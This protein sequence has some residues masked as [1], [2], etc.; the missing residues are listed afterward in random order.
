[1]AR[2]PFLSAAFFAALLSLTLGSCKTVAGRWLAAV[3]A[4]GVNLVFQVLDPRIED[5]DLEFKTLEHSLD[6]CD[7][8]IGSLIVDGQDL[9]VFY[10][11][12]SP[13]GGTTAS[14]ASLMRAR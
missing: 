12:R 5:G 10:H 9:L 4:V 11:R 13:P 14:S 2:M 3:S 6:Q 1:M 7:D 8:R